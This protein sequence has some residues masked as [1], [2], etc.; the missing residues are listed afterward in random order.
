MLSFS[1]FNNLV[2]GLLTINFYSL[3]HIFRCSSDLLS[4][5]ISDKDPE[6]ELDEPLSSCMDSLRSQS[7]INYS[8]LVFTS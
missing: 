4:E 6:I 8:F 7:F 5:D 3:S 1:I 2:F